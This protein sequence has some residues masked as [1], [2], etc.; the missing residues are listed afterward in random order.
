MKKN[1]VKLLILF[2]VLVLVLSFLGCGK[3]KKSERIASFQ[4]LLKGYL[5]KEVAISMWNPEKSKSITS[6]YIVTEVNVDYIVVKE[7][8][9]GEILESDKKEPGIANIAIPFHNITSVLLNS[10]PPTITLNDQILLTGFGETIDSLGYVGSRIERLDRT[11][12]KT[13]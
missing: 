2:L 11:K 3:L 1:V 8:L 5:E 4:K 12:P 13:E 6:N 10:T 9:E 7:K